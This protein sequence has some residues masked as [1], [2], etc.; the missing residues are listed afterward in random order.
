MSAATP[1]YLEV[2]DF[3]ARAITPES[4][5]AFRPSDSAQQRVTELLERQE[6]RLLTEAEQQELSDFVQLE[7][8]LIMAKAQARQRLSL[9]E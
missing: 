6:S 8:L 9:A 1:V 3:L 7:H 5:L 2:I 4:L